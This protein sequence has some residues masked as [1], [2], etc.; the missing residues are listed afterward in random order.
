RA[1]ARPPRLRRESRVRRGRRRRRRRRGRRRRRC[2]RACPS[3]R[4]APAR[5]RDGRSTLRGRPAPSRPR[6]RRS[7]SREASAGRLPAR[8]SRKRGASRGRPHIAVDY[9][10]RGASLRSVMPPARRPAAASSASHRARPV[11]GS[12][13][14]S[15]VGR[16]PWR[17]AVVGAT[18]GCWV[19][20]V[21][22]PPVRTFVLGRAFAPALRTP[23]VGAL[24]A[25]SGAPAAVTPPGWPAAVPPPGVPPPGVPPPGVPS[26]GVPPPGVP[27]PGP[28]SPGPPGPGPPLTVV[29]PT[30]ATP[31][32][33]L[34]LLPGPLPVPPR[35]TTGLMLEPAADA[36][37]AAFG[38][39]VCP[40]PIEPLEV[41]PPP[42]WATP[43]ELSAVL[44]P[45]PI[46]PDP[47]TEPEGPPLAE[48][49]EPRGDELT[50]PPWR[51]PAERVDLFPPPICTAPTELSAPLPEPPIEVAPP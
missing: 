1:R 5:S 25:A 6:Q 19:V 9:R 3:P 16:T 42:I 40:V 32:D 4:A 7:S 28:P 38:E 45:P 43:I 49:A 31:I 15:T 46:P 36:V 11:N 47:P 23:G 29:V 14:P 41:F 26:P 2:G 10:V 44:S 35:L 22:V 39:F 48:V 17:S 18:C 13:V 50:L 51:V 27:P 20:A 34:A 12:F 37:G 21:G 8:P 30:C 24:P 33:S